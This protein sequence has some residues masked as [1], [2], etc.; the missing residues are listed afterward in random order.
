MKRLINFIIHPVNL[1]MLVLTFL[2]ALP[3][4]LPKKDIIILNDNELRHRALSTKMLPIPTTYEELLKLVDN[5]ENPMTAEKIS[6]GKE[7]FFDPILSRD[8]DISCFSCHL[9]EQGGDDNLPTAI[10]FHGRENPFHLNSPTT[11]NAALA[12][13]QFWNA[14]AKDVE[15]QAGG[16]IQ[17]PFE[18]NMTPNEIEGRLNAHSKYPVKFKEVFLV[19]KISFKNV[20]DAIGAYE[21]TLLTHGAYDRFLEGNNSAISQ[22]A[23]RGMTIF[24]TKGCKGCHAGIAVGG[25]SVQQFPLRRYFSEYT[26]TVFDPSMKIR[27]NPFPFENKGGFLGKD[28]LLKFRV[29][30]L[31]NITKTAPYFHNGAVKKIEE[32]VRIMSKYQL[33]NEFTSEQIDEVVAFLETLEGN[34]VEYPK[35]IKLIQIKK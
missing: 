8:K 21:R 2:F 23:K 18:M 27:K 10:G 14:S 30:I 34:L 22:K 24:L 19:D 1:T 16:P 3:F 20:R 28:D 7:L 5:A 17:A 11:L 6:L 35:N 15:E 26:G 31:R 12:V 25:Q 33:G 13:R 29:P 4:I 9:L 32:V